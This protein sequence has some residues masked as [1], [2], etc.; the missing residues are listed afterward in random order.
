MVSPE[1]DH[2]ANPKLPNSNVYI[3][4]L[5]IYA[6]LALHIKLYDDMRY[7]GDHLLA[8]G[9]W[10]KILNIWDSMAS[11]KHY[12]NVTVKDFAERDLSRKKTKAG[13][14]HGEKFNI[15][16]ELIVTAPPPS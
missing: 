13:R 5:D 8:T 7:K 1:Y 10:N 15:E 2:P 11:S 3:L 6:N 12:R 9:Q 16:G 14:E 4:I